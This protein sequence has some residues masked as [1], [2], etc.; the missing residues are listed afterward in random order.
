MYKQIIQSLRDK[1]ENTLK[2]G[3]FTNIKGSDGQL[4]QIQIQTLRNIEDAMKV[5]Q[6]G[7]NSK[8]PIGSRSIVARIGNENIVIANEY[9]ASIIDIDSGD[10]IIY[11]QSG[12]FIKLAGNEIF[13]N[14]KVNFANNIEISGKIIGNT[15]SMNGLDGVSGTFTTV[16]AKT[17]TVTN[18]IITNIV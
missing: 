7:F 17:V 15:I 16:D 5:G 1:I 6:F 4:Q 11:N 13:S 12:T 2:I 8:A 18:G 14:K 10:T 9:Q 3:K